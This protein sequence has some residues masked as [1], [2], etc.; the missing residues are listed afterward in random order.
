MPNELQRVRERFIEAGGQVTQ[1]MGIGRVIGQIFAH[2]YFSPEPQTLDD[3]VHEL[4][5]SKGAA[6][7]SV[8]QLEQ[9]G[10]VKQV[11]IKGER[12]DYYEASEEFG[13]IIRRALLDLIGRRMETTDS[14][15]AEAE[16]QVANTDG[17]TTKAEQKFLKR[18]IGK[19]RTFRDRAQYI[20][21]SSVL[22]LL[23]K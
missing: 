7:M 22:K 2:L 14:L 5:I 19:I 15:L 6:S 8:R 3:L 20:W 21:D 4:S 18:R 1:S 17:N 9:W 10:A 23:M 16:Q 12:K 11:W 13:S